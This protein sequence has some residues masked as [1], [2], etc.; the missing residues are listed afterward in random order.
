[1]LPGYFAYLGSSLQCCFM[2][3]EICCRIVWGGGLRSL[4]V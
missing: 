3:H 4:Y 1:M 2:V